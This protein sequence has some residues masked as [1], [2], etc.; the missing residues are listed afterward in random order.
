MDINVI[1]KKR[2]GQNFLHDESI[3]Q[4]ILAS[5]NPKPNEN[6]LEI[7]PGLGA[8]TYP[9]L[10]RVK[11]LQVVEIDRD[12]P[13]LLRAKCANIP[14]SELIIH[15]NDALKFDFRTALSENQLAKN[16]KLRILG[17]LP[18]NISTPLL[19]HFLDYA[20]HIQDMTVML[21]KEVVDRLCAGADDDA[22]GRLSVSVAA[23]ADVEWIVHVGSG[24]FKPAPKVESA[25]VR[26]TPR[27]PDFEVL[28][29]QK[30][31]L[32]VRLAFSQRRKTIHNSLKPLNI[33]WANVP[34][35][36]PRCRAEN[37][38]PAQFARLANL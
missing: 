8:L 22:Y 10:Q 6:W 19:F 34:E 20:A 17:N 1:A 9:L 26:I 23:R 27:A 30:F 12:L 36:D 33:V 14:D 3:I 18:Y 24:A 37:L 15:E 4:K 28:D 11:K 31:D 16:E 32:V 21:Q 25:V 35:I 5:V 2:F 38:S 13:P 29:W 7:G